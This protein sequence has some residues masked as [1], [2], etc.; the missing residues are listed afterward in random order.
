MGLP[1]TGSRCRRSRRR[2]PCRRPA[3]GARSS[4]PRARLERRV[5]HARVAAPRDRVDRRRPMRR[6]ARAGRRRSRVRCRCGRRT[7]RAPLNAGYASEKLSEAAITAN[8]R[9]GTTSG[10]DS[11]GRSVV[12][13]RPAVD[14]LVARRPRCRARPTRSRRRCPSAES[15]KT[16]LMTS[17]SRESRTAPLHRP[18]GRRD[19]RSGRRAENARWLFARSPRMPAAV[20]CAALRPEAPV[21]T[22]RRRRRSLAGA[23]ES[24][25]SMMRTRALCAS[26]GAVMRAVVRLR[27]AG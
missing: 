22:R 10:P 23:D 17:G 11:V 12:L 9:A 26:G 20:G 15:Y 18:G 1:E 21:R 3:Y 8:P 25:A 27:N 4:G 5:E 7:R 16:S 14:V 19:R 13:E 24:G 2:C 6:S